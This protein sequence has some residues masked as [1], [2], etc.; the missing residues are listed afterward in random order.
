MAVKR[1][2]QHSESKMLALPIGLEVLQ[3]PKKLPALF[4]KRSFISINYSNRHMAWNFSKHS[5][6]CPFYLVPVYEW[7]PELWLHLVCLCPAAYFDYPCQILFAD[8]VTRCKVARLVRGWAGEMCTV[9]HNA[10]RGF[11]NGKT[12]SLEISGDYLVRYLSLIAINPYAV[13]V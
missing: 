11:T 9:M 1:M 4:S 6:V 8:L 12:V 5:K 3:L 10:L 2:L 13:C 7:D